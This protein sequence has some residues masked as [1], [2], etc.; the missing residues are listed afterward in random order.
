MAKHYMII[1]YE[2][3]SGNT[4]S[5]FPFAVWRLGMRSRTMVLEFGRDIN[6]YTED[7]P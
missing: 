6:M 1:Y 5:F 3:P 4:E 7:L 2:S